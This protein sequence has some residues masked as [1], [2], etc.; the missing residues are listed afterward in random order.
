MIE[1]SVGTKLFQN[2]YVKINKKKV[3]AVKGGR[4][5]CAFFVSF[6]LHNFNLIKKAHLTVDSTLDDMKKSG[7]RKI[8]KPRKNAVIEWE[9]KE[10]PNKSIHKH[11]GFYIGKNQAISTS[12]HYKKPVMHHITFGAKNSKTYRRIIAIYWHPKLN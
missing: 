3:D 9:R 4:L 8:K 2:F 10:F 6:I 1:N 5:S 12:S 7:W 11:I